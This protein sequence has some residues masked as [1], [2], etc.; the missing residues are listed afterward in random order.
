MAGALLLVLVAATAVRLWGLTDR[1]MTHIEIYVPG[2]PLP[3]DLSI[4]LPRF[5]I[6]E[7]LTGLLGYEEP[8][9]P[10]YYV[11][12]LGW[13]KLLGS[14]ILALRLPSVLFGVASVLLLYIFGAQLKER[15]AGLLAAAMLASN[16]HQILWSQLA[17][18]YIV[19]CFLGLLATVLLVRLTRKAGRQL[20]YQ[21]LYAGVV[22]AGLT[23]SHWFWALF[24]THILWVFRC[25]WRSKAI[26][27]TIRLQEAI[28]ILGTPLISLAIFQSR[29]NSYLDANALRGLA[30]FLQF[31]Y[32]FE[33]DAYSVPP[34]ALPAAVSAVLLL[35]TLLL[36]AAGLGSDR[37][38]ERVESTSVGPSWPMMAV[39]SVLAFLFILRMARFT[40]GYD[41]VRTRL[42][43]A[44]SVLPLLAAAGALIIE[45]YWERAGMLIASGIQRTSLLRVP[46]PL[47]SLSAF[48]V[49][50]PTGMIAAVSMVVP[51]F[52]SRGVMLFTPYLLFVLAQGMIALAR[53]SKYWLVLAAVL[54]VIHPG[55]V[56]YYKN[57]RHERPTEYKGLAEQ[58]IPQIE[59][60]DL[61]FVQPH[62]VT[63][64]IFYYLDAERYR[65]Y[66]SDYIAETRRHPDSRIWVLSF[67]GLPIPSDMAAAL[68]G[69][70]VRHKV[71]AFGIAATLYE[72]SAAE[73]DA[74]SYASSASVLNELEASFRYLVSRW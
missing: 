74:T 19:A 18:G 20:V 53:H 40:Y 46:K 34:I 24:A 54:A 64:P 70:E 26:P 52:A 51:F 6:R 39:G 8:H 14:S 25:H 27:G 48:L 36:L 33:P 59:E 57:T 42:V 72:H 9:P 1:T 7:T 62:W 73:G 71:E 47:D 56:L 65:V 28:F 69:Y 58:W 55:S 4:P 38:R 44:S 13:T 31:G 16:G 15:T 37:E 5:T 41:P 43:I 23:T 17:K 66:G 21:V 30:E 50:F 22:L 11:F 2:I 61:I 10:A 29:R 63:T 60:S 12:M 49:I 45:R 3:Q 35:M 32:L 68:A 67:E